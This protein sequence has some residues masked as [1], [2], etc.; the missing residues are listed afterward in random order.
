M[1]LEVA[2]CQVCVC[3]SILKFNSS[4][5]E[6][7]FDSPLAYFGEEFHMLHSLVCDC[8]ITLLESHFSILCG[9]LVNFLLFPIQ[10]IIERVGNLE[11]I[12][13]C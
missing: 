6:H 8:Q 9:F 10:F 1:N 12:K 7:N 3:F 5:F 11:S 4:F 2:L 13:G